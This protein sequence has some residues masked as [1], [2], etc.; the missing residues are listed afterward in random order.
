[1]KIRDV[2]FQRC[3]LGWLCKIGFNYTSCRQFSDEYHIVECARKYWLLA[4]F[5]AKWEMRFY[6]RI[7]G[8]KVGERAAKGR[9]D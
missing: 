4:F 3:Q 9:D 7:H 8:A 2:K 5:A 1:M 6:V